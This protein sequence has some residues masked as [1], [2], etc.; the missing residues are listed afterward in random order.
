MKYKGKILFLAC[1]IVITSSGL[2]A[3]QFFT[4]R[5]SVQLG[6]SFSFKS[7]GYEDGQYRD[8][9]FYLSPEINFFPINY[10]LVGPSIKM[11]IKK[12]TSDNLSIKIK[13]QFA[14]GGKIGFAYGKQIP[15]IPYAY[16]SPLFIIDSYKDDSDPGFGM[17]LN[18]GIIIPV[19]RHFSINF[20]TGFWFQSIDSNTSNTFFCAVGI[21]GLIF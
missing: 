3:A 14:M 13:S 16:G 12:R 17:E 20:G 2:N 18:G 21:T 4:A 7:T 1:F 11:D 15:V 10:L 5:G 8:N 19:Q 6:G 9:E